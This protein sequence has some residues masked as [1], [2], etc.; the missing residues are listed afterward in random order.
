MSANG[1]SDAPPTRPRV[2]GFPMPCRLGFLI[3]DTAGPCLAVHKAITTG[4]LPGC[5]VALVICNITGAPGVEA[6][7]AAGLRAVTLEGR[8]HDQREHEE[9]IDALLRRMGVDLLCLSGYR[10]VL[11]RSFIR[12][13]PGTILT[14]HASL[15]PA[16]PGARPE[17]QA[18][19]YGAQVTGYTVS[20]LNE[21]A[22]LTGG[23]PV[24]VQRAVRVEGNDTETILA[25]RLAP[26]ADLAYVDAIRR[27][28]SGL[29]ELEGRRYLLRSRE[30]RDAA[31]SEALEWESG[32]EEIQGQ[33]SAIER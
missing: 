6:A 18:I 11:S 25:A 1:F 21:S 9:A 20:I 33:E 32:T 15:L 26:E 14:G 17:R 4:V 10:R 28:A 16:F 7:R 12:R 5:T 22:D 3:S 13:W 31:P 30:G 29:Y 24:L 19:E 23:G 2:G 27:I 8:G